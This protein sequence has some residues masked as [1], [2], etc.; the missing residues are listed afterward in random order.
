MVPGAPSFNLYKKIKIPKLQV[1]YR[2][3]TG[4]LQVT[5]NGGRARAAKDRK[6]FWGMFKDIKIG[7][8]KI[9]E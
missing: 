4:Y 2:L 8:G 1:I 9:W 3:F 6:I 5:S 7:G